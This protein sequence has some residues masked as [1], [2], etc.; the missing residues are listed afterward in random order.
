LQT[1]FAFETKATSLALGQVLIVVPKSSAVVP[2]QVDA[3]SI[4]IMDDHINMVKFSSPKHSEFE[5]VASHL[6][7]MAD[8]APIK[9]QGNWQTER[10]VEASK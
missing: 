9:V 7:L 4:A 1:K 6:K 2:G 3:E 5:R 10:S 8:N